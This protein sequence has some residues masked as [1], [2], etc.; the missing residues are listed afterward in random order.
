[1]AAP[2]AGIGAGEAGEAG[3][4]SFFLASPPEPFAHQCFSGSGEAGEAEFTLI[5]LQIFLYGHD[6]C[7]EYLYLLH[8]PITLIL[9][10]F[11]REPISSNSA[12][13]AS[14]DR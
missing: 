13:P 4:P 6:P 9:N 7:H 8:S 14:P 1:L 12:S 2:S 10:F 11:A 5:A 3:E